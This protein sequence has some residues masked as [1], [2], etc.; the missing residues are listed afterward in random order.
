MTN[1]FR[2]PHLA[3]AKLFCFSVLLFALVIQGTSKNQG[4]RDS[5]ASNSGKVDDLVQAVMKQEHVPGLALAVVKDGKILKV[6]AYGLADV[7]QKI[8]A[9]TNTAFRIA[10]VSKQFVATAI[11]MLVEDGKL[12]FEDSVSKYVTGTPPK[13]K[14][15]T[16]RH[17]LTH[18][19]GIDRKSV[20]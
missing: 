6:Q 10:S 18:T 11:M 9:T 16:I 5:E 3:V 15:I 1:A 4:S 12:R 14:D 7:E 8:P 20:V 17:L 19:S 13:W 2:K